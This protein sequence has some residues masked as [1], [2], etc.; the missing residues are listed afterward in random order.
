MKM[1]TDEILVQGIAHND[2]KYCSDPKRLKNYDITKE[3]CM[4]VYASSLPACAARAEQKFPGEEYDSQAE[5]VAAGDI[6][7]TCI[8]D[9]LKG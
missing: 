5:F 1:W 7:I 3:K 2:D 6:I 8:N 9:D 4:T